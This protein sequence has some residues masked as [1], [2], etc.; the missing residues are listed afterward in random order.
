MGTF[1]RFEDIKAWKK[2][3]ELNQLIYDLTN[4]ESFQDDYSLKDQLR[5]AANSIML[6][7]SEGFGRKSGEEFRRFLYIAHG[8]ASEVKSALYISLDQSYITETQFEEANEMI[9]ETSKMISGLISYLSE[10]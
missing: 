1:E 3:R 4:Q 2:A 5:R 6:N 10:S 7:I 8:S 9:E